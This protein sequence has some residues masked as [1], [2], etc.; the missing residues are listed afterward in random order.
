MSNSAAVEM[1]ENEQRFVLAE[2]PRGTDTPPRSSV[3]PESALSAESFVPGSGHEDRDEDS[4]GPCNTIWK[5]DLEREGKEG[6]CF[7]A[8]AEP[9][10]NRRMCVRIPASLRTI[11]YYSYSY[12]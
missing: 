1:G 10:H 2:T 8:V 5:R 11:C 12:S 4:A 7:T 9:Y 3:F 6:S